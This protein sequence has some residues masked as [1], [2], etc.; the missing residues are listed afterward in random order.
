LAKRHIAT[1]TKQPCF[2]QPKA[3]FKVIG[4]F[5]KAKEVVPLPRS[6]SGMRFALFALTKFAT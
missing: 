4:E 6:Q 2:G 1:P 5:R 3:L